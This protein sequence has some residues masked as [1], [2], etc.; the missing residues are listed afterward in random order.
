MKSKANNLPTQ[1]MY[2]QLPHARGQGYKTCN[3]GHSP[4]VTSS[5]N[6]FIIKLLDSEY[7][8]FILV[9]TIEVANANTDRNTVK[10]KLI[11]LK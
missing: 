3:T 7:S 9:C 1:L 2:I 4:W 6:D 11:F 5:F 10:H 8:E